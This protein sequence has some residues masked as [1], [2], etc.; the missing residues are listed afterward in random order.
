MHL[1][2]PYAAHFPSPLKLC[3]SVVR[4]GSRMFNVYIEPPRTIMNHIIV[5]I[6]RYVEF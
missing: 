4:E 2:Y 5:E 3:N 1:N 6:A